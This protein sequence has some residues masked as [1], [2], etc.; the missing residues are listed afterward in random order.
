MNTS[1]TITKALIEAR[2]RDLLVQA[3]RARLAREAVQA[4][5]A[6]REASTAPRAAVRRRWWLPRL[7][8]IFG[9]N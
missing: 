5:K 8:G 1:P 3:G 7:T 9:A 2:H 4:S 6:A